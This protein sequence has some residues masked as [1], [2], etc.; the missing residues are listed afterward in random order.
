MH[1]CSVPRW[2]GEVERFYHRLNASSRE[3]VFLIYGPRTWRPSVMS[4]KAETPRMNCV[5]YSV[6]ARSSKRGSWNAS[7]EYNPKQ[8]TGRQGKRVI[9]SATRDSA[10]WA[11]QLPA[12]GTCSLTCHEDIV[13]TAAGDSVTN[14]L[15]RILKIRKRGGWWVGRCSLWLQDAD[16]SHRGKV[17]LAISSLTKG[18]S[19]PLKVIKRHL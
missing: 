2:F 10:R 8:G 12:S 19:G 15:G 14:K 16:V 6:A 9:V 1:G 13:T 11:E 3:C 7:A 4:E 17:C 5:I 18:P